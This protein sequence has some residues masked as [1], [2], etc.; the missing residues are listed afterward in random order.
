MRERNGKALRNSSLRRVRLKAWTAVGLARGCGPAPR[1]VEPVTMPLWVRSHNTRP[2]D[3]YALCGSRDAQWLGT[4]GVQGSEAFDIPARYSACAEGLMFFLVVQ[5]FGRGYWV[6]PFRPER[7]Q[8]VQMVIE[9]YAGLSSA[10]LY[11]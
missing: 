10:Q 4:V 11:P 5:N 7:T 1:G 9:K 6:G 2:V 3:V 8:N